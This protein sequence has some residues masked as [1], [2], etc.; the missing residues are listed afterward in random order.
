M[1]SPAAAGPWPTRRHNRGKGRGGSAIQE[2][3]NGART[4]PG[5]PGPEKGAHFEGL[6][7][8][9]TYASKT[10]VMSWPVSESTTTNTMPLNES[11]IGIVEALD[12][13]LQRKTK[14]RQKRA[15]RSP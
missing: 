8:R 12:T 3:A 15:S 7:S 5:K 6:R 9:M 11:G 4:P 2:L 14:L 1:L 13:P 10:W